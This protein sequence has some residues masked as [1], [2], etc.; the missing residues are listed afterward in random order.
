[1]APNIA[2]TMIARC[3]AAVN[4]RASIET[5]RAI[6]ADAVAAPEE[7]AALIP[8]PIDPEQDD[9]LYRS[10]TLFVTH[11][12]FPARF[13]TGIHDHGIPAL[14]G[15]WSGYED[16]YLFRRSGNRVVPEGKTRVSAGEVL[17]LDAD[18]AHDV[19]TPRES[20]S[21]AIH[22]YLG[23]LLAVERHAW[24]DPSSLPMPLDNDAQEAR[25]RAAAEATGLLA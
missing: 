23:D 24:E 2:E 19:H 10:D 7:M 18:M 1:M 11:A 9:V 22:V 16:N 15:V 17:V 20:W 25:W 5:L 8:V 13:R 21:G 4:R 3:R 14:I 6:V 12:V